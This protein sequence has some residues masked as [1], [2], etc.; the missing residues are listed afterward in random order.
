LL[1]MLGSS[2][3]GAGSGALFGALADYGVDDKFMKEVSIESL[4]TFAVHRRWA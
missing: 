1:L 2:D 3:V 4:P